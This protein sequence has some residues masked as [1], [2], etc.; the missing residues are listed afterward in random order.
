MT[1]GWMDARPGACIRLSS[2]PHSAV[3]APAAGGR[4]LRLSS[5][6]PSGRREWVVPIEAEGW[7]ADAWPKGGIFPL[8]PFSNRIRDGVLHWR[9]RSLRLER[10]PG[11]AHALHGHAQAGCWR[12]RDVG[13]DH[14]AM[15]YDHP[16]GAAGWPWAWRLD[17]DVR[18]SDAGLEVRL[19]LANR[20]DEPM[21]AGLGLHPYFTAAR[22]RLEASVL[23]EHEEELASRPRPNAASA[24]ER[25][26]DT[27][28]AFLA[29]WNGTCRLDWDE[30]PGL[31]IDADLDHVVLHAP[32][33]R[34]LC[35][36]PVS[37]VC[38]AFNL[39]AAGAEGTGLRVLDPGGTLRARIA[40]SWLPD[41]LRK[42]NF[43]A[44]P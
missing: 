24:W 23:W 3:V 18:L 4:I 42:G 32:Q 21:P 44:V 19:V 5:D 2:G 13:D 27:W 36:E 15:R 6:T 17:Q 34:Y 12:L 41:G 16:P 22:A 11:Q 33:G 35:V 10:Y 8:A 20:S 37:H 9:G 25:G 30:G 39:A 28:T 31:R 1:P 40:F 26:T 29:G 38:D 7:P 14:V 43:P